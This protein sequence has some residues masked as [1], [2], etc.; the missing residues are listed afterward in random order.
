MNNFKISQTDREQFRT[1]FNDTFLLDLLAAP[2]W[3]NDPYN[4]I[5]L[6]SGFNVPRAF[7]IAEDKVIA[8]AFT[9]QNTPR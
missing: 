8:G 9:K 3:G 7:Q 2:M 4:H 5:G 6:G 1:D